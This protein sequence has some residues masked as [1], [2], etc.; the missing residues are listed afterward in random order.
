MTTTLPLL[1]AQQAI[2][3]V[4]DSADATEAAQ[5]L[6]AS[7]LQRLLVRADQQRVVALQAQPLLGREHHVRVTPCLLLDTGTRQVQLLG[8]LAQLD[9]SSLQ[10]A[11]MRQ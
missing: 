4:S 3:F 2:L 7:T 1:T 6:L 11:L 5:Q 10:Q 8:P 9:D